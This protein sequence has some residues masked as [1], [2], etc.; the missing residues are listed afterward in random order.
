MEDKMGELFGIEWNETPISL[1]GIDGAIIYSNDEIGSV[2]VSSNALYNSFDFKSDNY[3]ALCLIREKSISGYPFAICMKNEKDIFINWNHGKNTTIEHNELLNDFPVNIVELQKRSLMNIYN[4]YPKYGQNIEK[5]DQYM[6]FSENDDDFFFILK[7]MKIKELLEINLTK[8]SSSFIYSLPAY[9]G[10]EGWSIIENN[11]NQSISK[12]V[13]IAM[14]FDPSMEKAYMSIEKAVKELGFTIMRIDRKQHNNEISGE[15]LYE[16]KK[17]K[18]L[19]ADVTNHRNGVYFEAGFAMGEKK[20]VIWSCR[21]DDISNAH[22]D[23]RQYNH[24]LWNN[25][26]ELYTKIKDRILSTIVINEK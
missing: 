15:I 23:T 16:I 17:S 24:V 18:L 22:F 2:I 3:K 1:T 12:Q 9:I 21:Q 11:I 19:I 26:D 25:E 5:L 4:E 6:F 8:T 20:I 13:F 14:W 7:A 10:E